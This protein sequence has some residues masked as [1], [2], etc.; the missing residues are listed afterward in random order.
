MEIDAVRVMHPQFKRG[1]L[2]H[3][4]SCN[5]GSLGKTGVFVRFLMGKT[6]RTFETPSIFGVAIVGVDSAHNQSGFVYRP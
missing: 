1:K 6:F 5:N 4:N 2:P 3:G